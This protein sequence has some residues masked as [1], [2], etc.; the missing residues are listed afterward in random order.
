MKVKDSFKKGRPT[1]S[2]E[3]FPPK[4]TDQEKALFV[5]VSSLKKFN[6]DFVSVTYGAGGSTSDKSFDIVSSIK[7]QCGI[8]PVAHITCVGEDE[9]MMFMKMDKL[10]NLDIINILALRGDLP[11]NDINKLSR[12]MNAGDLTAFI[13]TNFPDS[14][15]GVAGYPEKHPQAV[16]LDE[17]ILHLK[18]KVDAGADYVITQLFFENDIYFSFVEKCAKAG[19][20]VPIIPGIMP[21]SSVKQIDTMIQKCG[22]SIPPCIM[23]KIN[24]YREDKDSLSK[25]GIELAT[26]QCRQLLKNEVPGMHFFVLNKSEPISQILKNIL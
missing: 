7:E 6:P 25:Y 22:A 3:F 1:L 10:N 19:I 4:T 20:S 8:E 12:F 26:N 24:L 21:I 17:D 18:E 16:S 23:E 9:S 14:C 5:V 11:A 2:F 15:I 13:K